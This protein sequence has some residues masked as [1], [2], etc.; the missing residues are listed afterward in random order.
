MPLTKVV[1]RHAGHRHTLCAVRLKGRESG[2]SPR[3]S[4]PPANPLLLGLTCRLREPTGTMRKGGK[5][6]IP[7]PDRSNLYQTPG[8]G[9]LSCPFVTR[10]PLGGRSRWWPTPLQK[11]RGKLTSRTSALKGGTV[12]G[13][14]I[15][16]AQPCEQ[17]QATA[18][19]TPPHSMTPR[20]SSGKGAGN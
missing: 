15:H 10:T 18:L 11:A 6:R 17:P 14:G 16:C 19:S 4:H 12:G 8:A 7:D 1:L 3:A 9:S 2:A 5:D 13:P 20:E